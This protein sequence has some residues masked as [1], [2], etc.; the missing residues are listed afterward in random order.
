MSED[1]I[2]EDEDALYLA[3][4]VNSNGSVDLDQD[5]D[6]N[7]PRRADAG[8]NGEARLINLNPGDG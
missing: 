5:V 3:G 8:A 7:E 2:D 1:D 6:E 4:D